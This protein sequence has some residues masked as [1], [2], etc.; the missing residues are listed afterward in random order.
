[1]TNNY[2]DILKIKK[3][4]KINLPLMRKD[5]KLLPDILN[6]NETIITFINSNTNPQGILCLTNKRILYVSKKLNAKNSLLGRNVGVN[7]ISIF[8]DK[9][10]SISSENDFIY[11]KLSI[12]DGSKSYHFEKLTRTEIER[13]K[14]FIQNELN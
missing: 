10:N 12:N 5:L 13:F 11:S 9:V 14:D 1:M 2:D 6:S 8:L 7:Q 4:Q 3:E